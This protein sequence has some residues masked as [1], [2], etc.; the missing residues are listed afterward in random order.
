MSKYLLTTVALCTVFLAMLAMGRPTITAEGSL[1]AVAPAESMQPRTFATANS[2][3][4]PILLDTRV[5]TTSVLRQNANGA[6]SWDIIAEDASALGTPGQVG[7][8]A[9]AT[10][11][12]TQSV[13]RI[14]SRNGSSWILGPDKASSTA[15]TL[16]W[17][18]V[19][20]AGAPRGNEGKPGWL[21]IGVEDADG[22]DATPG[23]RVTSLSPGGP[24]EKQGLQKDD[25]LMSAND[26]DLYSFE[27]LREFLSSKKA[28]DVVT[29]KLVRVI[30]IGET[31]TPATIP[32]SITLGERSTG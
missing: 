8:F 29:F 6:F 21:G 3:F 20:F 25:V 23:L 11:D 14:D 22:N 12:S 2:E 32:L 5:G 17:I 7:T 19:P 31:P 28:G 27:Q 24:A 30:K 10:I 4:G 16:A 18:R 26:K 13:L 1:L 15:G 9:L